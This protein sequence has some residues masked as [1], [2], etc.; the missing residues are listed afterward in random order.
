M[1]PHTI[2]GGMGWLNKI[3]SR[4]YRKNKKWYLVF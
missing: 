3:K 2:L 4:D 1:F